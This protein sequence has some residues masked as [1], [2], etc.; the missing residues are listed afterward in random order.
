MG[1]LAGFVVDRIAIPATAMSMLP[2]VDGLA[3]QFVQSVHLLDAIRKC[4]ELIWQ[5][6]STAQSE[7]EGRFHRWRIASK[8]I[9]QS[10][11]AVHKMVLI[12]HP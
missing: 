6:R 1:Q 9:L 8:Q 4:P 5:E 10:D 2:S 12:V 11:Y 7:P 3:P